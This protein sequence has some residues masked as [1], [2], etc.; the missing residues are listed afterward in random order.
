LRDL[1]RNGV[2]TVFV[3]DCAAGAPAAQ[4][5]QLAIALGGGFSP[6]P[7]PWDIALLR[8]SIELLPTL[9]ALSRDHTTRIERARHTVMAPNLLCVA[10]AFSF[11][12]TGLAAVFI[13]NFGTS[14]VYNN[15][16]R[17]LRTVRDPVTEWRD[18]YWCEDAATASDWPNS[19]LGEG[20]EMEMHHDQP[21]A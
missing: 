4:E 7:Q 14:I 6:E 13:S 18:T 5:A 20:Y 17:S 15:V 11:G 10:G 19:R 2:P 16:M 3:G 9:F 1:G 8:P 21:A 12:L